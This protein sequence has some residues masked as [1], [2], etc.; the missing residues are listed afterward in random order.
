MVESSDFNVTNSLNDQDSFL[1]YIVSCR[2]P[3]SSPNA[4]NQCVQFYYENKSIGK[5]F[6]SLDNNQI[7][8]LETHYCSTMKLR[9]SSPTQLVLNQM[10]INLLSQFFS[11]PDEP[12]RKETIEGTYKEQLAIAAYKYNISLIDIQAEVIRKKGSHSCLLL[13]SRFFVRSWRVWGFGRERDQFRQ[14]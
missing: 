11:F 8:D 10:W 6:C 13:G 2:N 4:K 12:T 9:V 14:N 1:R 7:V 5:N 3:T